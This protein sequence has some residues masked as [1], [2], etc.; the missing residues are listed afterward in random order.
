[1]YEFDYFAKQEDINDRYRATNEKIVITITLGEYRMLVSDNVRLECRNQRLCD[2]LDEANRKIEE[3][4][5]QC[6]IK[7]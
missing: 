2:E 1:M 3:L 7:N 5:N 6:P 4:K